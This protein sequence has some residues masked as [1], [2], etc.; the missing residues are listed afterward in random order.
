VGDETVGLT[1]A[2]Q[3]GI[4][5]MAA[6]QARRHH[7]RASPAV[8]AQDRWCRCGGVA[9]EP[10]RWCRCCGVPDEPHR[11]CRRKNAG[12]GMMAARA[13]SS[14]E[15]GAT[16]RGSSPALAH[17]FVTYLYKKGPTP[18]QHSPPQPLSSFLCLATSKK[19]GPAR[20]NDGEDRSPST[21]TT[22]WQV[23]LGYLDAHADLRGRWLASTH[24][25]PH[26]RYDSH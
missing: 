17:L 20:S 8:Q 7:R 19:I 6:A 16:A 21:T 11:W 14:A 25:A 23:H 22:R 2:V 12:A 4:A 24:S 5:G 15:G 10:H 26:E 9:G 3:T 18:H 1:G 13:S